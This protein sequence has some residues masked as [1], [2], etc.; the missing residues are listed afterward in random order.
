MLDPSLLLCPAPLRQK[1]KLDTELRGGAWGPGRSLSTVL[2]DAA[3]IP[4]WEPPSQHLLH[5]LGPTPQRLQLQ[6]QVSVVFS[7]SGE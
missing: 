2:L 4:T 1:S 3:A 6:E 5:Q 7:L